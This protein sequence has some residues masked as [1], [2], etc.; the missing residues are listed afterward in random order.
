M[1]TTFRNRA[2]KT[3]D[4]EM[5]ELRDRMRM[6]QN[7]RK[8][9]IDIL[10]A[11]KAA[12]REEIKRFREEN[13]VPSSDEPPR[14]APDVLTRCAYLMAQEIRKRLATL[15]RDNDKSDGDTGTGEIMGLRSEVVK[16]R[17]QYDNLR[18]ANAEYEQGISDLRDELRT[19]ELENKRP[20]QGN[21]PMM[22]K[23]RVLENR[24]DKAMI[25][26]NEAMNIKKTYEEIVKRL[27]DERVGFDNQIASFER[28]LAG[29]N[30]DYQELLLL[31][32]D[33]NHARE[34]AQHELEKIRKGYEAE[35]KRRDKDL[36]EKHQ[37]LQVRKQMKQRQ[38]KREEMRSSVVLDAAGDV[39]IQAEAFLKASL[40]SN[41]D[42]AA[43]AGAQKEEHQSKIDIF[44]NAFRKIKKATGVSD[45]N[46]VIQ[47]VVSQEGTAESLMLLTK[48]NQQ[49]I[50]KYHGMKNEL[51]QR[52][53]EMKYSGTNKG[54][55]RKLVDDMEE[56][57]AASATHLERVR[58]KYGRLA[59]SVI[60][61][62]A[63]VAHLQEKL[64]AIRE[65]LGVEDGTTL[66]DESIV[67]VLNECEGVAT[68]LL[69]RVKA[70][71]EAEV[72]M[73]RMSASATTEAEEDF[74]QVSDMEMLQARPFNQRIEL[75]TLLEDF[76]QTSRDHEEGIPEME[77]DELTRDKIKKASKHII[78]A[79]E[80]KQRRK[81]R[82]KKEN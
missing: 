74:R 7:D 35:R 52:I 30:R 58:M 54:H 47:K 25:K 56:K 14:P 67:E 12:N 15:K 23:I 80:K 55:R 10:E 18:S 33:A 8:T 51:R 49:K 59:R 61:A 36:R 48:E 71:E 5:E 13:K 66:T 57:L 45:V 32:G 29:K 20:K 6:L 46:E 37:M 17:A 78:A 38:D 62:K 43:R 28:T 82:K 76:E 42:A 79:Q 53:E 16:L 4:E 9:N 65:E 1:S 22:Q 64:A 2:E 70:A 75:P 68:K 73:R 72:L 39:D 41:Q 77:D 11:N 26:Y 60:S 69:Q 24:L 27:R 21:S 19:V 3:I 50:D 34:V 44:Q 31:S 63:G 81:P 40:E